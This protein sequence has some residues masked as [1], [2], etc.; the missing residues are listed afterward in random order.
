MRISNAKSFP[1]LWCFGFFSPRRRR[2]SVI[3]SISS[4]IFCRRFWAIIM[5]FQF[6][7]FFRICSNDI[8]NEKKG[9]RRKEGY[10]CQRWSGA[11]ATGL[12]LL[13][14]SGA[15]S[16]LGSRSPCINPEIAAEMWLRKEAPTSRVVSIFVFFNSCFITSDGP[17]EKSS[18]REGT[19]RQ[20]EPWQSF[21]GLFSGQFFFLLFIFAGYMQLQGRVTRRDEEW[22]TNIGSLLT[23]SSLAMLHHVSLFEVSPPLRFIYEV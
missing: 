19:M 18:G 10:V 15:L 8:K 3:G 22:A 13:G 23:L 2:P 7:R 4:Q 14:I 16:L 6:E 12:L 9:V 20:R 11:C 17:R 1:A 21:P 5:D